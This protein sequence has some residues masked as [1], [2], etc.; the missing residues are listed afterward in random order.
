MTID[1]L[2]TIGRITTTTSIGGAVL[3]EVSPHPFQFWVWGIAAVSG[4]VAIAL[5]CV[6][7]YVTVKKIRD[8]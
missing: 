3:G 7:I 5:G 6:R 1:T 2:D 8:E 4:L